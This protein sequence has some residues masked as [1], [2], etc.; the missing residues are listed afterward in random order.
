MRTALTIIAFALPLVSAAAPDAPA[1][2]RGAPVRRISLETKLKSIVV[3]EVDFVDARVE[4]VF[5]FIV[6]ASREYDTVSSEGRK[7]ANIVLNIT[8]PER[9]KTVTFRGKKFSVM[10]LIETLCTIARVNY[11][12]QGNF[13]MVTSRGVAAEGDAR[14][15]RTYAVPLTLVGEIRKEGAKKYFESMGIS[16]PK[17]ASARYIGSTGK[18]IVVNT[19]RNVQMLDKLVRGLGGRVLK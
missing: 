14:I 11:T 18:L 4:D 3:P 8:Q 6:D 17:G 12:I 5:G 19:P 13:L 7:G 2:I 9:D 16:F 15:V 10:Q 1:R